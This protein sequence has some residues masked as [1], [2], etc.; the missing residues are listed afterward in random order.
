[1]MNNRGFTLTEILIAVAIIGVLV[2]IGLPIA[3]G[4]KRKAQQTTCLSTLRGLGVGLEAYLSDHNGSMP[5][6][7]MGRRSKDDE[8]KAVLETELLPYMG[9]NEFAFQCSAD[10]EH[11][12]QTGSSYFWNENLSGFR[13]DK[14]TFMGAAS[15]LSVIPLIFDKEAYHGD[16]NGVNFLYADHSTKNSVQFET[17]SKN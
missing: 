2:S 10:H 8:S 1:M 9:D 17:G 7:Y 12:E 15:D 6:L 4:M 11:F 16:E 14:L 13:R 5:E 3:S